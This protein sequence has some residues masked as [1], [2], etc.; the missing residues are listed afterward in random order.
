VFSN[1]LLRLY[2]VLTGIARSLGHLMGE[3]GQEQH[4][5]HPYQRCL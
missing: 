5:L 2:S 1:E 3:A 4:R